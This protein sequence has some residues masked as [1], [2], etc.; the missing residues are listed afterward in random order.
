MA[1]SWAVMRTVPTGLSRAERSAVSSA[2]SSLNIGDRRLSRRVP[3]SVAET[4]RVVRVSRRTPRRASSA[5][6]AWLRAER[7]MPSCA[8]ARVKLRSCATATKARR[9]FRFSAG[10]GAFHAHACSYFS[11]LSTNDLVPKL[12]HMPCQGAKTHPAPSF[13]IE[14][15]QEPS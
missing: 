4:L 9:S 15:T 8:A 1:W 5:V 11:I 10:I 2:S 3:A 6:M 13:S 14:Q 7:D 12:S